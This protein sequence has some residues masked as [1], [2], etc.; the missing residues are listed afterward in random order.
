M[1]GMSSD[2]A[3]L[4]LIRIGALTVALRWEFWRPC[5]VL[6]AFGWAALFGPMMIDFT[7]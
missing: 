5:L 2:A 7:R 6:H 3:E 1:S 4:T